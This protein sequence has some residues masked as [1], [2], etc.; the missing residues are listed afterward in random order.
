M[1][2]LLVT[3]DSTLS[4]PVSPSHLRWSHDSLTADLPLR[5][6]TERP[7]RFPRHFRHARDMPPGGHG[8]LQKCMPGDA[9]RISQS[10]IGSVR[11]PD[12]KI[13]CL[14]VTSEKIPK[15]LGRISRKVAEL[16]RSRISAV[17]SVC[18]HPSCSGKPTTSTVLTP[19][20]CQA[21]TSEEFCA[22]GGPRNI[23]RR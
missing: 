4:K 1:I 12:T 22:E 20:D 7:C 11:C 8:F 23:R 3:L 2:S 17:D 21:T 14:Q 18:M 9:S 6:S 19:S 16:Q 15:E 5:S 13:H 10:D